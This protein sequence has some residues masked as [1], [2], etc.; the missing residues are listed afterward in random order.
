MIWVGERRSRRWA[1]IYVGRSWCWWVTRTTDATDCVLVHHWIACK[2]RSMTKNVRK[3]DKITKQQ[4]TKRRKRTNTQFEIFCTTSPSGFYLFAGF[5]VFFFSLLLLLLFFIS[6]ILKVVEKFY[7]RF[8]Y[9]QKLLF[10]SRFYSFFFR[11][12]F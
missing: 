7:Q 8:G 2:E 6:S 9:W 5:F 1:C 11:F 4:Y 3:R 12:L 10:S